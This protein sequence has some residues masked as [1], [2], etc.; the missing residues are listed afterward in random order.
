M[1]SMWTKD[2][3]DFERP[4]MITA[5][6]S[7]V[8]ANRAQCPAIPYTPEEYAAEA[9]RSY[10]AGAAVERAGDAQTASRAASRAK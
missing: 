7:G 8:V 4:C 6:L 5:A 9:K 2:N 1:P 3:K 10:E